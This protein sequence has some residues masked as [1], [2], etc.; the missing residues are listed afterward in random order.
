MKNRVTDTPP[1]L[2][3]PSMADMRQLLLDAQFD[4]Q[5]LNGPR[6]R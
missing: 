5:E 3:N 2:V 1:A 4:K 6:D